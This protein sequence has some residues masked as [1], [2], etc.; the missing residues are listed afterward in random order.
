MPRTSRSLSVREVR[1][2]LPRLE[3]VLREVG[4]ITVTR[5][6]QPV[7]RLLPIRARRA[8]P[9]HADLRA[10]MKPLRQPSERL[11]RA[12]RDAR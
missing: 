12:D 2:A 11:V 9:T 10:S 7:A 1:A 4:E 8:K 5:H 6:G 3:D